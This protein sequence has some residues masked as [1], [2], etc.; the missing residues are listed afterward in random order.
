[1][2]VG[3]GGTPKNA[4]GTAPATAGF[5]TNANG[6][7]AGNVFGSNST[8]GTQNGNGKSGN[9][10]SGS[11]IISIGCIVVIGVVGMVML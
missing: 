1:M 3:P 6:T 9:T 4:N 2:L 10:A 7:Q 8:N 5:I 11:L